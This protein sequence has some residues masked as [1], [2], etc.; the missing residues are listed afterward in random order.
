VI[1]RVG[2]ADPTKLLEKF[3]EETLTNFYVFWMEYSLKLQKESLPIKL[4]KF[5]KDGTPVTHGVVEIYDLA[6]VSL[7]QLNVWALN[8]LSRVLKIGAEHYPENLHRGFFVNAPV[9]FSAAWKVVRVVLPAATQARISVSSS[10]NVDELLKYISPE[11]LP[12]FLGGTDTSF[13]AMT[14]Q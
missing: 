8:S 1:M 12:D 6:G 5:E 9:L 10:A 14:P 3:N 2:K 7:S 11:N 13:P 4:E